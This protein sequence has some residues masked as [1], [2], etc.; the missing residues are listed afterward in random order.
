MDSVG[1]HT[2]LCEI[3]SHSQGGCRVEGPAF[4]RPLIVKRS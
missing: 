2:R 3:T 4:I 1:P